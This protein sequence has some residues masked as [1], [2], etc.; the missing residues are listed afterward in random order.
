N[1][2]ELR[3]FR[4]RFGIPIGDDELH[5][6]PFYRPPENSVEIKYLLERR[7]QL[8]GFLPNRRDEWGERIANRR[9][10]LQEQPSGEGDKG[11]SRENETEDSGGTSND[12]STSP[13]TT[14]H[15]PP[16][17]LPIPPLESFAEFLEGSGERKVATIMAFV[18]LLSRLIRDEKLGKYIVP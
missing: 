1:D 2:Q 11:R 6:A 7:K 3:E 9:A 13:L 18:R 17:N 8:G 12:S 5:Q 15:P 4:S 16:T 10:A 14:H